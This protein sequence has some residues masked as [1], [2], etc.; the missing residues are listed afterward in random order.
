MTL[1][2]S[3]LS[4]NEY[5]GASMFEKSKWVLKQCLQKKLENH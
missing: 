2:V 5:K 1:I 3:Q 4:S